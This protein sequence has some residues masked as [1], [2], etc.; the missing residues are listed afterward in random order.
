MNGSN[1]HL[2][3]AAREA[4]Q[5]ANIVAPT[6]LTAVISG[7]AH[8]LQALQDTDQCYEVFDAFNKD[9]GFIRFSFI[10]P[11][12]PAKVQIQLADEHRYASLL[13]WLIRELRNWRCAEDPRYEKLVV[14]L[15]V[16]QTCDSRRG[17][18]DLLPNDIGA[19]ADLL[20]NLK[21]LIASFGIA[22]NARPGAQVPI[23]EVEAVEE[24]KRADAAGD[25]VAVIRG[26]Q[27]FRHQ[28]FLANTLQMQAV[29]ALYRFSFKH[30][31]Q[32]LGNLRQT[33]I[34]MQLVSVLTIEQ[35]LRLAIASDNPYV[36]IAAMY[37]T[38]TDER[39]PQ[40]LTNADQRLLTDLLLKVASDAT[41]WAE[42]MKIFAGYA[43]LQLPLGRALAKVPHPAIEGYVA[44]ILLYP[45]PV[46]H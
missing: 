14:A 15:V 39:R 13:R 12:N 40:N 16:A 27:Q 46:G 4:A 5:D 26:W 29:R 31:V 30:L 7:L 18:W 17:L 9:F 36:Q 42:W 28:P 37:R 8:P 44:S 22:F 38:L 1:D 24:F 19:N 11:P 41:R 34:A 33:P 3:K 23:W 6:A 2:A 10:V 35:R 25:W 20:D 43:A 21:G 32:S 45:K